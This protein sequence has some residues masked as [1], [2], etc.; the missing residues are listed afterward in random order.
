MKYLQYFA[1]FITLLSS[2]QVCCTFQIVWM[3][4]DMGDPII[5]TY[6]R[7]DPG[8]HGHHVIVKDTQLISPNCDARITVTRRNIGRSPLVYQRSSSNKPY[9]P[10]FTVGLKPDALQIA[11]LYAL[12]M[13]AEQPSFCRYFQTRIY[14]II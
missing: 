3:I 1:L 9:C 2:H 4:N 13:E 10:Q 5:I 14:W 8:F 6:Y 7:P 12:P 11:R